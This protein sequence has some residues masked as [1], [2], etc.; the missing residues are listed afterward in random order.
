MKMLTCVLKVQVNESNIKI[1]YW[2]LCITFNL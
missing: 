2:N 1:V